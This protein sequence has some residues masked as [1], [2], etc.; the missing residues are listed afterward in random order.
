METSDRANAE[1]QD[2]LTKTTP[3]M[4][5]AIAEQLLLE[6]KEIMDSLGVKFFLSNANTKR[7]FVF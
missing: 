7:R 5:V 4:D 2:R 1:L 3:P 6:V